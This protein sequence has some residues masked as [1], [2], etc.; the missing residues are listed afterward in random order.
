MNKREIIITL[1]AILC[2]VYGGVDYFVLSKPLA[3]NNEDRFVQETQ[4][5]QA[6]AATTGTAV[7]RV[8]SIIGQPDLPY[9][10][11]MEDGSFVAKLPEFTI[12][13]SSIPFPSPL[14]GAPGNKISY[15]FDGFP[16]DKE[17]MYREFLKRVFPIMHDRLGPPAESFNCVI[18]NMGVDTNYFMIVDNGRT[19]LSDTD[20]IPRLIVHE[21]IHAWKGQYTITNDHNWEYDNALS[22]FEEGTAEGMAFE[23]VHEYV[24]CYP[25]DDAT[26]QLL[27]WKPYQ[28]WSSKTTYYDSIKHDSATGS[29]DFWT[30]SGQVS[31]RYS[32]AA[33]TIQMM[34]KEYADFYKEMSVLYFDKINND[35]DWRPIREDILDIWHSVVP[36]ING[37]DTKT[38]LKS[39]PVFQGN[40]MFEGVSVLSVLR[41]YGSIGDQQFAVSYVP[42]DGQVYWGIKKSE[43]QEY[44]LPSWVRYDPG[45]DPYYYIDTQNEPFTVD[46]YDSFD[47]I[48]SSNSY[49]TRYDR[50]S[51][52]TATG[53]GWLMTYDVDMENFPVGLYKES[54]FFTNLLLH[55]PNAGDEY[56]FF[57]LNGLDQDRETEYLIM[58]GIDGVSQG[59]VSIVID[60]IQYIEPIVNGAAV[61][62]SDIWPFDLEGSFQIMV[63]NDSGN[64]HTYYR[65]LLEAGTIHNYYQHQ[66]IIVDKEF[67][68]IEDQFEIVMSNTAP[69]IV[70]IPDQVV[71][72]GQSVE[73]Q[74]QATDAENDNLVFSTPTLNLP[75]TAYFDPETGL[76]S[77]TPDTTGNYTCVFFVDDLKDRSSMSVSI[78][79]D[80]E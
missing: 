76:F 61:F 66:F 26:L 9:L 46:V 43:I 52:G 56:Y 65:T 18:T 1:I 24:R 49:F 10:I 57:G 40:K 32:I 55:D 78:D 33:T 60:N 22:G 13:L 11:T 72:I 20:F 44:N 42:K 37:V 29:G 12:D 5:I 70:P 14:V 51:D 23:I 63:T 17:L 58:I 75:D 35:P 54:V 45:A 79:V 73:F 4:K 28:Y 19:F 8:E 6:F 16:A 3:S 36:T 34:V 15:T 68:G 7:A 74:I 64:T 38:Y 67:N 48:V 31:T 71:A 50:R 25:N 69:D 77:W 2:G 39:L 80:V 41:P 30:S 47:Q 53:F 27:S 21:F 62:R 59:E